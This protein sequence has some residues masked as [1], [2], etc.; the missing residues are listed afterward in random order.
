MTMV[1][2]DP[3]LP[4]EPLTLLEVPK[5][6]HCFDQWWPLYPRKIAKPDALK[7]FTRL[8]VGERL[9]LA[10]S[11]PLWVAYF[12]LREARFV[13]YPATFIRSLAWAELPPDERPEP[14]GWSGI[15]AML[16]A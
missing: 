15:R 10:E 12:A 3:M 13:P 8:R 9:V 5:G 11:T 4:M 6:N 14:A 1:P 7:A 16:D 2:M